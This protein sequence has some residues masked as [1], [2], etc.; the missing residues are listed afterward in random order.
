MSSESNRNGRAFEYACIHSLQR[1]F[2]TKVR[3]TIVRD[4]QY[5]DRE[6]KW[7]ECA[8]DLQSIFSRASEA[9]V[10]AFMRM[11]PMIEDEGTEPLRLKFISDKAAERGD[12]R[13]ILIA[14]WD[15]GWS[16]GLSVKHNHDAVKHSRLADGLDF[17]EKWFGFKCTYDY[18]VEVAPVF[19]R[20]REDEKGKRWRD[21]ADKE[22]TVYVPL[23]QAF[24]REI[25]R[26]YEEHG[27]L[28][29]KRM[30]EYLLGTEDYYKLISVDKDRMTSLL[31]FNFH[32]SLGKSSSKK[33][34]YYPVV[35]SPLPERIIGIDI[36]P[37]SKTTVEVFLDKG[38]SLSFRIHSAASFVETSL[39]FDIRLMG[40]PPTVICT[41]YK[42]Y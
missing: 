25:K 24:I 26:Q 22:D 21:I 28:V 41:S 40:Q 7:G 39:K 18:W 10:T 8:D 13:D 6:E 33:S 42:W 31:C 30:V 9:P 3:T 4:D 27:S 14:R 36:K 5:D 11:E 32:G 17:C 2:S 16:V 37:G 12:P 1:V 20:L 23:L 38:W 35:L 29:P 19:K 34:P 15:K